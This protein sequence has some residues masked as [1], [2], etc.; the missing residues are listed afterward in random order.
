MD[1]TLR[2]IGELLLQSVPTVI[3]MV[4]L[5]GLYSVLV[6]KPLVSVLAERRSK[7]EG[8]VEKARADMAEAES[9]TTEYEQKLR[10]ARMVMF[11]SQEARRQE[12][13]KARAAVVAE[14]RT[15][16]Q[17][18]ILE[19]RAAI[20][21]DKVAAQETLQSESGRLAIEIIRMVLRPRN[22]EAPVG[23]R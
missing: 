19:A 16:A 5:Y 13:A 8:A 1:E 23:A 18:Q 9:R 17:A 11:K 7:T 21:K 2:E 6:H 12:A 14:A 3:F 15:R 4:L 22:P 20:E 10:D